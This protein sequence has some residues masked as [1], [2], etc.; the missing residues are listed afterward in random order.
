MSDI[1]G[2]LDMEKL[3]KTLAEVPDE[4]KFV[5][6]VVHPKPEEQPCS[7]PES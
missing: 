5:G 3:T 7:T 1:V 2:Y 6:T 4:F